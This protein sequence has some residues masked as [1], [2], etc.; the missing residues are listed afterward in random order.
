[1]TFILSAGV[2]TMAVKLCVRNIF[3]L[4]FILSTTKPLYPLKHKLLLKVKVILIHSLQ[5]FNFY[6]LWKDQKTVIYFDIFGG[7][8]I[9]KKLSQNQFASWVLTGN[10]EN[11]KFNSYLNWIPCIIRFYLTYYI[12]KRVFLVAFLKE[13]SDVTLRLCI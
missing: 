3:S 10:L 9:W 6:F 7:R 5:E 8:Y 12:F 2:C 11:I 1:M 13:I 4:G